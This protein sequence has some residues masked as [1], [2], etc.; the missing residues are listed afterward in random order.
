MKVLSGDKFAGII[1]LDTERAAKDGVGWISLCYLSPEFR[2]Q[3]LGAQLLG[4]AI[5]V[6]RGLGRK[7][8]RLHVAETN[9]RG[10]EFYEKHDF[11]RIG[12]AKGNLCSLL[13]MEKEI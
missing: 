7:T 2:G 5:S 11:K 1:E 4:H 3:N 9:K 12:A 10:I 13:L 6:Y 8:L